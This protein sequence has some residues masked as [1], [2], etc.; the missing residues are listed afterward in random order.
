MK[1]EPNTSQLRFM[2]KTAKARARA[3]ELA[4]E[5]ASLELMD[6]GSRV[7]LHREVSR[8]RNWESA[9]SF[10]RTIFVER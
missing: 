7:G 2:E 4:E 8:R 3:T 5:A 6:T 9:S 1:R 10:S